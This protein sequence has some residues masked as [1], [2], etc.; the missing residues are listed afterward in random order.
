MKPDGAIWCSL[1]A[2]C[3]VHKHTELGE[4]VAKPLLVLEPGN[5]GVYV[6]SSNIYAGA[7]RCVDVARIKTFLNNKEE[8]EIITTKT[9]LTL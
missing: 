5:P 4:S 2:A 7:G 9:Y 3:R 1:L 6:L 8:Q